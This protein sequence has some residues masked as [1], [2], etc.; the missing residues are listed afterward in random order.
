M[1]NAPLSNPL[2]MPFGSQREKNDSKMQ[3]TWDAL[4]LWVPTGPIAFF[5]KHPLHTY[6]FWYRPSFCLARWSRILPLA[7]VIQML[8]LRQGAWKTRSAYTSCVSSVKWS[9]VSNK[10]NC[11]IDVCRDSPSMQWNG[12]YLTLLEAVKKC[13]HTCTM[14]GLHTRPSIKAVW[15]V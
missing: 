8:W 6:P 3:V 11:T 1:I 2:N 9:H 13:T 15:P 5:F 7:A 4:F 12:W 14:D 10:E